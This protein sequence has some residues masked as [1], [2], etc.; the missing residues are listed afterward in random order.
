M[1]CTFVP[2]PIPLELYFSCNWPNGEANISSRSWLPPPKGISKISGGGRGAAGGG[3][4]GR[5]RGGGGGGGGG[6]VSQVMWGSNLKGLVALIDI[7][8][9]FRP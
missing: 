2:L 5:P 4:G 6:G 1:L 7:L 3:G 8:Y 9:I